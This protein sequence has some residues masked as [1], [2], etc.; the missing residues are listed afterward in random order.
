MP[1]FSKSG[2]RYRL[3]LYIKETFR[4]R[5]K[6]DRLHGPNKN[7][8]VEYSIITLD[9]RGEQGLKRLAKRA[10]STY[11]GMFVSALIYD[12]QNGQLMAK[13]TFDKRLL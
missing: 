7:M 5:F 1:V 12:N 2:S 6:M 9:K 11:R 4:S 3:V 10:E 13:W 8:I